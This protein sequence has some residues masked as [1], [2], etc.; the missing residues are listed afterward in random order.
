MLRWDDY[1]PKED[2]A[3]RNNVAFI[4]ILVLLLAVAAGCLI[5]FA[6][7]ITAHEPPPGKPFCKEGH[8]V[9]HNE[10]TAIRCVRQS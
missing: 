4:V 6:D 3:P 7:S 5:A 9:I 2:E 10:G 1:S 8:L